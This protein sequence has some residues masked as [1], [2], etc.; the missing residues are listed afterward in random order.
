MLLIAGLL[1]SLQAILLKTTVPLCRSPRP[2][3]FF[4]TPVLL[5]RFVVV[6]SQVARGEHQLFSVPRDGVLALLF[7]LQFGN[8]TARDDGPKD[9]DASDTSVAYGVFVYII[10]TGKW[11]RE[12][13]PPPMPM[14]P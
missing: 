10:S 7:L 5:S 14:L 3:D 6:L 12:S 11:Q 1:F 4:A 8:P 2:P 9:G 13:A